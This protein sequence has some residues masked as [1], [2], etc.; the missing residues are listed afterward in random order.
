MA[1]PKKTLTRIQD[2]SRR[3]KLSLASSVKVVKNPAKDVRNGKLG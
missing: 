3:V 2:I 1:Y